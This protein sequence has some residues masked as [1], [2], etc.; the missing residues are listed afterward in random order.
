MDYVCSTTTTIEQVNINNYS[1][2]VYV[3]VCNVSM[4]VDGV[5]DLNAAELDAVVARITVLAMQLMIPH[6]D[7]GAI[8][9]IPELHVADAALE[10]VDVIKQQQGFNYHGSSASW[11]KAQTNRDYYALIFGKKIIYLSTTQVP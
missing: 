1:I 7:I 3:C 2:Y 5:P 8:Q 10:A 9:S 11:L 6:T 4:Y